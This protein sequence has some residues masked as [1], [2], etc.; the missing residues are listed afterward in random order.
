[1]SF[2]ATSIDTTSLPQA[3]LADAKA[4]LRVDFDFDDA[5]IVDLLARSIGEWEARAELAINPSEWVWSPA[6]ADFDTSGSARVPITPVLS[7][8][9]TAPDPADAS[10]PPLDVSAD[11][12][13]TT[14]YSS[15]AIRYRLDGGWL[16]DMSVAIVSGYTAELLPAELRGRIFDTLSRNYDFRSEVRTGSLDMMPEYRNFQFAPWWNPKA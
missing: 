9:V 3:L 1:M 5:L 2:A 10:G 7:F 6:A 4:H 12:S 13:L 8:A 15:G 11:Y 16:A 14:A